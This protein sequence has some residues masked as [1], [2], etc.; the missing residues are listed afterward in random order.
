MNLI[1]VDPG[2]TKAGIAFF[3]MGKLKYS[4]QLDFKVSDTFYTRLRAFKRAL[5][6][7]CL[8]FGIVDYFAVETPFI[9][10]NPQVGLKLGMARGIVLSLAFDME[11]K[12]IDIAP[13]QTRAYYGVSIRSKK[14]DYQKLVKLEFPGKVRGEDE[15]DAVAIGTTAHHLIKQKLLLEKYN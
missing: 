12:I 7:V 11:A 6:R 10:P 3:Q 15:A 2:S 8:K 14:Q 5:E 4:E 9:G 13:Q 1:S